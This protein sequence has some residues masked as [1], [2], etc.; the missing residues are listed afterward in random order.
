MRHRRVSG[1]EPAKGCTA[2][3]S[4]G[5]LAWANRLPVADLFR[6]KRFMQPSTA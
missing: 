6:L 2:A 1:R 3:G 4:A 5:G